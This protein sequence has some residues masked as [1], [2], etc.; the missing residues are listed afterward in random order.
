MDHLLV[1]PRCLERAALLCA[2]ATILSIGM[3]AAFSQD[4][5]KT[6]ERCLYAAN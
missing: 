3:T 4:R 5:G 2:T 1:I 6:S